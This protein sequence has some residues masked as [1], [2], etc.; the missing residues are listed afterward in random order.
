MTCDH[1]NPETFKAVRTDER[2]CTYMVCQKCGRFMG[3][4][5]PKNQKE[6]SGKRSRKS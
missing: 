5:A 6:A 3:Y 4:T 2:G 1:N